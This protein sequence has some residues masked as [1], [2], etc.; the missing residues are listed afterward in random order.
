MPVIHLSPRKPATAS[1]VAA[2]EFEPLPADA[3]VPEGFDDI[4]F[5]LK[6]A[7]A[8]ASKDK[9]ELVAAVLHA[10]PDGTQEMLDHLDAAEGRLTTLAEL[11]GAA[12]AR[13]I[14]GMGVV[15]AQG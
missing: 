5:A 3:P 13:L 1:E 9:G 11:V 6:L 15:V 10:G 8:I 14:I 12:Q 7:H 4:E 2:V